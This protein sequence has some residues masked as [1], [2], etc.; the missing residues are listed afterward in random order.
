MT[1]IICCMSSRASSL[2]AGIGLNVSNATPTTC[3][4]SILCDMLAKADISEGSAASSATA[5]IPRELLL[6]SL[7]NVLEHHLAVFE[8]HGFA[9]LRNSYM[10]AWMHSYALPSSLHAF[11]CFDERLHL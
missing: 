4:D 5:S 10:A 9:P 6:A 11:D 3:L 1:Y 2:H 7:C 8:A